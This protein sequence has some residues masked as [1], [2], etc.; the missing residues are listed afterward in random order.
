VTRALGY[1]HDGRAPRGLRM[2][3]AAVGVA[4]SQPEL[5]MFRGRFRMDAHDCRGALTDF[6]FADQQRPNNPVTFA[7][8]ALA[9]MCLGDSTGARAS[10]ER[11]LQLDANQPLLRRMLGQ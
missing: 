6:Q 9:Q 3:D 8:E 7:S 1:Q 4:P 5:R 11:S 2:L 10:I